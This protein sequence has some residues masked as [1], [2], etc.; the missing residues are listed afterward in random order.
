MNGTTC[1]IDLSCN[2]YANCTYCGQGTGYI[3]VGATCVKC[4][5]IANCSQCSQTKSQICSICLS[6]YH[7]K[8]NLCESCP[9]NCITCISQTLCTGCQSGYTLVNSTKQS[10]CLQCSSPCL[11]CQNFQSYC[12]SCISGY[13]KIGWK[14]QMNINVGFNITLSADMAT[15]LIAVDSIV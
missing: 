15:T 2:K 7:L 11:T 14:C 8:N 9:S 3:L 4:G 6:G 5:Q 12:T 13:T 10:Q 1:I